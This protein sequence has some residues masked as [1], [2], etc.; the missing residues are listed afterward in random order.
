MPVGR[1]IDLTGCNYGLQRR[2][3]VF[4]N[5]PVSYYYFLAG[6]VSSQ[7]LSYILELGTHF[8]GSI[9]S[10]SKGL[11]EESIPKSRLVTV[12]Q[13]MENIEGFK[14]YPHIIRIQG[15]ILDPDILHKVIGQF[16]RPIDL[17]FIDSS[18]KYEHVKEVLD[19]YAH[20]LKPRF[21]ILDDIF[22]NDPMKEL[23]LK[24]TEEFGER[25]FD[26]T[27]VSRRGKGDSIGFGVINFNK[28]VAN[29]TPC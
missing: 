13:D 26:A 21:I 19:L 7:R 28:I 10:M 2:T 18:H 24:I 29:E 4:I 23:W 6:F 5:K 22:L 14:E 17:L 27:Q 8:G 20:M 16:D 15:R 1:K 25:A 11:N 9:M 12:D 3:G